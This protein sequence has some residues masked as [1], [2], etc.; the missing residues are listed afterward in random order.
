MAQNSVIW[1][2]WQKFEIGGYNSE[3][4]SIAKEVTEVPDD[5]PPLEFFRDNT[6]EVGGIGGNWTILQDGRIKMDFGLAGMYITC[7]G[8]IEN[9]IL[10]I[11]SDEEYSK[12]YK[13][14]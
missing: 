12:Y 7:F 1:G 4:K 5:L 10:I 11:S 8:S 3:G 6:L 13:I 14:N 9:D 2:K